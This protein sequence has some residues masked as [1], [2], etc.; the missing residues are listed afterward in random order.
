MQLAD[1]RPERGVD[2]ALDRYGQL[3]VYGDDPGTGSAVAMTK[4][5]MMTGYKKVRMFMGGMSE[6]KR[7]GLP[8]EGESGA[9]AGEWDC[10]RSGDRV[11]NEKG[12]GSASHAPSL[13]GV[14]RPGSVGQMRLSGKAKPTGAG[15]VPQPPSRKKS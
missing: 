1:V 7:A 2:P 8:V 15:A 4:R 14:C 9:G 11:K 5:L 13:C 10:R 12:R 6:W 3:V